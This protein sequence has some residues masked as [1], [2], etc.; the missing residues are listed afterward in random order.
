MPEKFADFGNDLRALQETFFRIRVR[1]EV[2]I[3]LARNLFFVRDAMPFFRKRAERFRDEFVGAGAHG[4]FAGFRDEKLAAHADKVPDVDHFFEMLVVAVFAENVARE[5]NLLHAVAV[6]KFHEARF[7]HDA[8][9]DNAPGDGNFL[10]RGRDF[11]NVRSRGF[12]GV[13]G[14][15]HEGNA[16]F[17]SVRLVPVSAERIFA[18]G[19][20]LVELFH[21]HGKKVVRNICERVG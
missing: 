4:N 2:E 5:I 21:A 13:D 8:N 15:L 6:E 3:T 16:V 7:A 12:C 11:V 1:D 20:Q 9:G 18:G 19:A 10:G 14:G 17:G